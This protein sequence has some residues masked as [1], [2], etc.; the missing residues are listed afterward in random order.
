MSKKIIIRIVAVAAFIMGLMPTITGTR[1]LTGSFNPG[2]TT[3]P[4][5]ISYNIFMGLVSIA[6]AYFIWKKHKLAIGISGLIAGG[7]ILVLLSL[8][9]VFNDIIAH[10]SIK[11]MIVRSI[12]WIAIFLFVRKVTNCPAKAEDTGN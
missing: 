8:L 1:A 9:T 6:A 7:H 10:Q 2:Y 5:L 4:L 12:I 3:F 11:A